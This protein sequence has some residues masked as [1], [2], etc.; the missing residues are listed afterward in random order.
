[1]NTE[2]EEV[3]EDFVDT[4]IVPPTLLVSVWAPPGNEITTLAVPPAA[5]LSEAGRT[6]AVPSALVTE[7]LA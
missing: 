3:P 7:A 6:L 4:S 5:G 1:M 2:T